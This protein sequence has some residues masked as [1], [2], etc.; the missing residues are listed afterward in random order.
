MHILYCIF[1]SM[2]DKTFLPNFQMISHCKLMVVMMNKYFID[3]SES[4]YY[5]SIID[6]NNKKETLCIY[7]FMCVLC[8][9]VLHT[10]K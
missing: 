6:K 2:S 4:L 8:V 10:E 9:C 3:R 7:I 5:G 1:F